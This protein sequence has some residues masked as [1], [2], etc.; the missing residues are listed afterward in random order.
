VAGDH[1]WRL[2][3]A[4]LALIRT[5]L[6]RR[7]PGP[8]SDEAVPTVLDVGAW[9]GWLSSRLAADGYRVVGCDLFAGPSAL[10]ARDHREDDWLA[11]QLD[12]MH[13]DPLELRFDA[14]IL[15]RCLQYFPNPVTALGK[16]RSVLTR[17]GLIIA[18]GIA[19]SRQPENTRRRLEE[20]RST[21][22]QRFHMDL[23][24]RP[25]KGFF[26]EDDVAR[27]ERAGLVTERYPDMGATGLRARFDR[28]RP[29]HRYGVLDAAVS[30]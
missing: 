24:V 15:N 23:L 26:D 27:L 12:P 2:R 8:W 25:A 11:V 17:G 16:V 13:L 18:T 4:D 28:S 22:R 30:P 7:H 1:E 6:A 29:D 21:F 3:R 5:L 10:G 20:E 19:V 14:I 9:N